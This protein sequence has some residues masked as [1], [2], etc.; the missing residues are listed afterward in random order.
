MIVVANV[1]TG[2]PV[3]SQ[4]VFWASL[5]TI[6]FN[7]VWN[8]VLFVLSRRALRAEAEADNDSEP[9]GADA[10]LWVFLVP[11]LDEALTI[12]DSVER[13]HAVEATNKTSW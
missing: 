11:A 2:L 10:F 13:L 8:T 6:V 7:L 5:A 9:G 4:V 3:W 12:A 1:F